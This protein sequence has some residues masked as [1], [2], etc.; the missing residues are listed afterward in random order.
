MKDNQKEKRLRGPEVISKEEYDEI[1][2]EEENKMLDSVNEPSTI[3]EFDTSSID[4]I[5][6]NCN[7]DNDFEFET[8]EKEK[9]LSPMKKQKMVKRIQLTDGKIYQGVLESIEA[10]YLDYKHLGILSFNYIVKLNE[11][12][13][14]EVED[15]YFFSEEKLKNFKVNEEK[16]IRML[17]KFDV[18]LTDDDFED[19]KSLK[20]AV[21]HLIGKKVKLVQIT[22]GDYENIKI[23]EV[24]N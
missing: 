2:R 20:K 14:K 3:D 1:C 19:V 9:E 21:E 17:K 11:K 23:V 13:C 4:S 5:P 10:R 8:E 18:R 24:L 12:M 15:V 16:L 22:N 6:E 7:G